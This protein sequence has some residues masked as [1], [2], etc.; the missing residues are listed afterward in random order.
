MNTKTSFYCLRSPVKTFFFCVIWELYGGPQPCH[1]KNKNLTAKTKYLTANKSKNPTAKPNV[2][3]WAK[4]L[5]FCR[6]YLLLPWGVWFFAVKYLVL[7]WDLW[8]CREVFGFVVG[9]FDFAVRFLLLPW[10]FW[11]CHDTVVGHRSRSCAAKNVLKNKE[12]THCDQLSLLSAV[13]SSWEKTHLLSI[14]IQF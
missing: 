11:F 9:Y 3:Q 8:F 7:P 5:W 13:T 4:W 6:G 14:P 2:S 12:N 10:G 1:G